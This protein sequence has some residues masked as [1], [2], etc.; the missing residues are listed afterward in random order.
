MKQRLDLAKL[1]RILTWHLSMLRVLHAAFKIFYEI[2]IDKRIYKHPANSNIPPRTIV[3]V[4][5]LFIAQSA[6]PF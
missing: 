4:Y 1:I 3:V 5:G 6:V 2:A